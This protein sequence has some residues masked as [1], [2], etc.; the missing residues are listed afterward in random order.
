MR[1]ELTAEAQRWFLAALAD[2]PRN[3]EALVGVART[4]QHIVGQPWWADSHEVAVASDLGREAVSTAL[5][6][7]PE[8]A[9]AQ[10]IKGMLCSEA[11]RLKEAA[12]LFE[13]ALAAGPGLGIA[14]G[15]AGYNA[16]FL[17]HAEATLPAS[18]R[19]LRLDRTDRRRS[20]FFFFGGFGELL[21]GRTEA[22]IALLQK[23]L[24]RNPGYGA[25]RL[26]TA[27]ALSLIGRRG[28]AGRA[29]ASFRERYPGCRS[30]AF[31]QLWLSRSDNPTYRRQMA[32]LFERIQAL[33][34]VE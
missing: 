34:A 29:A 19:A 4:C 28:E 11:G 10:C 20:I 13:R 22:A 31:A 18:E 8:R 16:A 33:G 24:E 21:L 3:V 14:E 23:S 15:F 1:A 2:N 32:P 25:A 26:F 6:L 5:S 17:G 12:N 27:A 9:F 7:A 30:D